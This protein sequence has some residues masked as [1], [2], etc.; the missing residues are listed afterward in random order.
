L[1][2]DRGVPAFEQEKALNFV[3]CKAVS[4]QYGGLGQEEIVQ[5]EKSSR[6]VVYLFPFEVG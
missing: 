4:A 3:F 2:C 6:R 5:H 1:A